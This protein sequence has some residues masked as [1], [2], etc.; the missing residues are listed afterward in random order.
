MHACSIYR[1][2]YEHTIKYIDAESGLRA[3]GKPWQ[4][5]NI[6]LL[7][8]TSV[9]P[10][11]ANNQAKVQHDMEGHTAHLSKSASSE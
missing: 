3:E 11:N 8:L 7:R 5:Q 4:L 2:L 10:V 6:I 1:T 9:D